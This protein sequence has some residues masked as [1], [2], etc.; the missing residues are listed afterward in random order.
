MKI[1]SL[2][3]CTLLMACGVVVAQESLLNSAAQ[4]LEAEQAVNSAPAGAES[5]IKDAALQKLKDATPAQVQQGLDVASKLKGQVNAAPKSTADAVSAVES[6]AKQ[7][8]AEKAL[9]LLR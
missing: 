6:T 2:A 7:Q 9:E 8:A 4:A 3:F 5:F 1:Q